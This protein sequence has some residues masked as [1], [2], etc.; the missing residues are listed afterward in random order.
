MHGVNVAN[1]HENLALIACFTVKYCLTVTEGKLHKK[2]FNKGYLYI[3]N[4]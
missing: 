2:D 1:E 3:K 4:L